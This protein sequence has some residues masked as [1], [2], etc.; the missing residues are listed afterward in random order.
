[1][2]SGKHWN[3]CQ[4]SH[5]LQL[6]YTGPGGKVF[7]KHNDNWKQMVKTVPDSDSTVGILTCSGTFVWDGKWK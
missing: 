7:Y 2:V 4:D 6:Q 3:Q 5:L 1:M